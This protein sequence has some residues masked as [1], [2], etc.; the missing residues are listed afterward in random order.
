[1]SGFDENP[2]GEPVF[3]DPFKV[4]S[5]KN[6]KTWKFP[7]FWLFLLIPTFSLSYQYLLS[8]WFIEIGSKHTTSCS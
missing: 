2:F 3:N 8:L 1:M 6:V 4:N 5:G 7:Y